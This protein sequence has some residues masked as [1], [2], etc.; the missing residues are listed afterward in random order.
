MEIRQL[1]ATEAAVERYARE[2]WL[3]YHR[4]LAAAVE[5]HA[6]ADRPDEELIEAETGFRLDR[7]SGDGSHRIWVV[8]TDPGT[9]ARETGP[10]GLDFDAL[11]PAPVGTLD[12]EADL[13]AF[14]STDVDGC[15]AVFDRP[16]RLVVGD[17]YVAPPFRGSG[18]ADRLLDRA[19][20]D[21]RDRGCGQLRL[22]VDV[23]NGRAVSFYER[24]GF[25]EYRKQL[26][27]GVGRP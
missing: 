24:A 2:L 5:S 9:D 15:P 16:D 26:T 7:R 4:D 13:V 10:G 6:L 27:M 17:L 14:V 11:D 23:D 25:E 20:A 18:L 1:P 19:V 22:D 21:A 3:P 12:P 8:T